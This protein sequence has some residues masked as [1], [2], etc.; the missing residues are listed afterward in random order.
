MI[1]LDTAI[2][3]VLLTETTAAFFNGVTADSKGEATMD[4]DDYAQQFFIPPFATHK[5]IQ[6]F[7]SRSMPA[8]GCVTRVE[9]STT[10]TSLTKWYSSVLIHLDSFE[11]VATLAT[12]LVSKS[13]PGSHAI[14]SSCPLWTSMTSAQS[15]LMTI[16]RAF[17]R[18]RS[19]ASSN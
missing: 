16:P 5:D 3:Q 10:H 13:F 15:H 11:L 4:E 17:P 18:Q 7:V 6:L 14:Q 2:P 9:S 19:C 1:R 12:Q 8:E